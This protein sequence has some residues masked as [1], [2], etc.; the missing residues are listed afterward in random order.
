MPAKNLCQT[1]NTFNNNPS[2]VPEVP[3]ETV[4]E[5]APDV[6]EMFVMPEVV[7]Q[8]DGYRSLLPEDAIPNLQTVL[9]SCGGLMVSFRW[10][11]F[12]GC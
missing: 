5:A 4:L 2:L 8:E 6:V 3:T 7:P 9:A 12:V 10:G 11:I 1:P